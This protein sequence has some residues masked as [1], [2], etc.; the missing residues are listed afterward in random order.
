MATILLA[1]D[2]ELVRETIAAYLTSNGGFEVHTA[3]SVDEAIE[4]LSRH[5]KIDLAIFDYQMPG[6]NGLEGFAQLRSCY[7]MLKTAVMSGVASSQVA[8]EA[9]Q[10][11]ALAFFPKSISVSS[12]VEGIRGLL[13]D[14]GLEVAEVSGGAPDACQLQARFGLTDREVEILNMVAQGQSN[15]VIAGELKLKETTIKFHVSNL[16]SK[17]GVSNRTQ[18][19]LLAKTEATA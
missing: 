12:M 2:H 5:A 16:M 19:A 18:A 15:K 3:P 6:M 17:L 14:A 4:I 11:G 9:I 1:D 8:E 13:V 10:L 7:P